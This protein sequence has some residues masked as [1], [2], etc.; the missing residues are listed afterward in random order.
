MSGL[1]LILVEAVANLKASVMAKE[2][3]LREIKEK[4]K[5]YYDCRRKRKLLEEKEKKV[6]S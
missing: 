2:T 6:E 1:K 5:Y 3:E 4:I